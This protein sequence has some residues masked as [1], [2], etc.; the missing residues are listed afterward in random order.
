[1]NLVDR[2]F[3]LFHAAAPEDLMMGHFLPEKGRAFAPHCDQSVLHSEDSG[4]RHCQKYPDWQAL[5]RRQRINFTGEHD[6]KKAPCPSESFRDL[7]TI[8]RWPG[9]RPRT[10]IDDGTMF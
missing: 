1:M 9:N 5:R 6:P 2:F 8:Y 4:C 7:S 10:G 3:K